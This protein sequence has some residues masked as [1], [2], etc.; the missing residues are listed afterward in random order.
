[1]KTHTDQT[2]TF[3]GSKEI[4]I[5]D[6]IKDVAFTVLIQYPTCAKPSPTAFGPYLMDVCVDAPVKEGRFPL[7]VI[8]HGS[9]GSHLL[10]RTISTCLVKNGFIVAMAE[11]YGNN[12][13][14]NVLENSEEN[15]ILRPRHVSLTIDELISGDL[16]G[17]HIMD[18]KIAVIGHSLG[19]FTA[20]ALAGGTARTR[21]GKLIA[22]TSDPRVR[23]IVLLAPGT[24]WFTRGLDKVTIPILMLTA[25]LD[26]VTPPWN[27][28]VILNGVPDRSKVIHRQVKNAGHFSF[29]SPF[30]DTMVSPAFMPS[31][32]PEGFDRKKFHDQLT[33][34]ILDFLIEKLMI[35]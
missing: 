17:R 13:N 14:N 29:L 2:D 26:P 9:G 12:R 20:V 1:M 19:G 5:H 25:E 22:T 28:E 7:V 24:G 11:H 10:Y 3:V 8:S 18:D 31:T 30:P 32:D 33:V 6:K 34:E 21:E 27:A 23:V 4:R 16:L 15:L 35:R